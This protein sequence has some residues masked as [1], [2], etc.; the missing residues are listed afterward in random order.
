MI[1]SHPRNGGAG[2]AEVDERNWTD[3]MSGAGVGFGEGWV[4]GARRVGWRS[5]SG[6]MG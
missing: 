2:G 6:E 3:R 5:L 4:A 1:W